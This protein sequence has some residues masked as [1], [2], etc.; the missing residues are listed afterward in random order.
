MFHDEFPHTWASPFERFMRWQRTHA[1]ELVARD[2]DLQKVIEKTEARELNRVV[3]EAAQHQRPA[4]KL[5][6]Q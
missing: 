6:Q 3:E 5:L 4:S 2:E 1:L